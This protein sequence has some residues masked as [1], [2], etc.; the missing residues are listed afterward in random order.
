[1]Y[2]EIHGAGRPL[3]LNQQAHGRTGDVDRPLG[4][5]QMADDTAALLRQLEIEEAAI[6]GHSMGG[7]IALEMAIR[8]PD[9]VR[10]LVVAA[11]Y[12]DPDGYYPEVRGPIENPRPADLAGSPWQ[13]AHAGVAPNPEDWPT[14]LAEVRQR[15]DRGFEGWA[16]E[17]V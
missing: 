4:Y 16:A 14:L 2:C 8:H 15:L 12:H 6:F 10:R 13:E 17:A 5:E 7:G 9:L 11:S 3:A 1:M